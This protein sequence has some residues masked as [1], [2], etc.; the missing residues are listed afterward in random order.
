M[1][2][3]TDRSLRISPTVCPAATAG[4]DASLDVRLRQR[5]RRPEA[6]FLPRPQVAVS[7]RPRD[8]CCRGYDVDR[9]IVERHRM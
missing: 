9:E 8:A 7:G 2:M 1:I 5:D 3:S 6:Q 4:R